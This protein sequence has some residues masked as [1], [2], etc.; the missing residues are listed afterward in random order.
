MK[1]SCGLVLCFLGFVA[2]MVAGVLETLHVTG[3]D[4]DLYHA[5]QMEAGILE[6][7]GISEEDLIR[8]DKMLA[9]YLKGGRNALELEI[10]VFGER[11]QALNERECAHMEDCQRLF[12]LLRKTKAMLWILGALA[13]CAGC[14]WARDRRGIRVAAWMALLLIV[15]ALGLFAAWA[16][17]D[18]DAA[19]ECFHRMLFDNLL[20]RLNPDT[21]L[22]IRICPASMFQQMGL[23]IGLLGLAWLLVVLGQAM[24]FTRKQK[25]RM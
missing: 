2:L 24:L 5:L 17:M 3:T 11:Q 13:L 20:W 22:L 1:K 21:D 19:F 6:D 12:A 8:L 4:A 14:L 7:A 10:D 15:S 25:E 9:A 18:F 16:A 23:R